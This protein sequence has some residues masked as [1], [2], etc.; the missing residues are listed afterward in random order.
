[1][2]MKG[3]CYFIKF[4]ELMSDYFILEIILKKFKLS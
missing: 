4:I 2:F 1:M 3:L